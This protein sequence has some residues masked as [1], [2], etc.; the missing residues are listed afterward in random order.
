[1]YAR[2]R[3]AL[4]LVLGLVALGWGTYAWASALTAAR[5]TKRLATPLQY[6]TQRNLTI[7][8][9]EVIYQGGLVALNTSTG[10]VQMASDTAGLQVLGVA[11]QTVDNADDGEVL[12]PPAVGVFCFASSGIA[13]TDKGKTVYVYDDQTVALTTT[14]YVV[15]GVLVDYTSEGAWV[16]VDPATTSRQGVGALAAGAVTTTALA[17][18]AVTAAKVAAGT[19]NSG[20]PSGALLHSLTI[21]GGAAGDSLWTLDRAVRIVD[22]WAVHTGG[23]GEASDTIRVYSDTSPVCDAMS[24]S[25]DTSSSLHRAAQLTPTTIASGS[26]LK[27][28][29]TDNDSG[30]D[31]GAGV[32]YLLT[33]PQ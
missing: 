25:G 26:P 6:A 15:A 12:A 21:T 7:L 28:T 30:A 29:T 10:E 5:N 24:W 20:T 8:D 2:L 18:G 16:L 32:L 9:E 22:V 31:V 4:V 11:T 33:I 23:P 3:T 17:T 27:V 14:N 1:M 13:A 19:L